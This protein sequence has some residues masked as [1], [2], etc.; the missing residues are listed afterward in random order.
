MSERGKTISREELYQ[1]VWRT[2]VSKLTVEW[3]V[4]TVCIVKACTEL[5]VPRPGAGHWTL[6][7][8]GWQLE[9]EALPPA[10]PGSPTVA[11][12]GAAHPRGARRG[13]EAEGTTAPV[14]PVPAEVRSPHPLVARLKQSLAEAKPHYIYGFLNLWVRQR[15]FRVR[16]TRGQARRAICIL[17]AF[18]KAVEKRGAKFVPTQGNEWL[19]EPRLHGEGVSFLLSEQFDR[20]VRK[21]ADRQSVYGHRYEYHPTGRLRFTLDG[22]TPARCQK[23]WTDGERYQLEE[24]V[25]EMVESV[26]AIFE[27]IRVFREQQR[28][29]DAER[30]AQ[31]AM[32]E[33]QQRRE[34]M[35]LEYRKG[36]E[37]TAEVWARARRLE[38][39]I[40]ACE[41]ELRRAG[42]E[43]RADGWEA[44][45]LAWAREHA[46]RLDPIRGGYLERERKRW[47]A[48]PSPAP[49][50]CEGLADPD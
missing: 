33:E 38:E 23:E 44:R 50:T 34:A 19:Y 46:A 35:E 43:L 47:A 36:L 10:A 41:A 49:T 28:K 30:Q 40:A 6:V 32:W 37:S 11:R 15:V 16:V 9:R 20:T 48:P 39:F 27:G 29:E 26:Y 2:P 3:G 5:N 18:V 21:E 7:R 31:R 45:W 25:G 13:G 22:F 12:I 24:V 1:A 17:D 4:P 42:G 8:R 14:V